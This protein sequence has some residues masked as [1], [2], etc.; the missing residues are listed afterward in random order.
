MAIPQKPL[1]EYYINSVNDL[2]ATLEDYAVY[3]LS[4]VIDLGNGSISLPL[5]SQLVGITANSGITSTLTNPISGTDWKLRVTNVLINGDM[6]GN[7]V[8][9]SLNS[10]ELVNL[11]TQQNGTTVWLEDLQILATYKNGKWF[12]LTTGNEV[13]VLVF[14]EDWESGNFTTNGWQVVNDTTNQWIVGQADPYTGLYSAYISN[15]GVNPTYT[16]NIPNVSHIYKDIYVAPMNNG[17]N[18]EFMFKGVLEVNYDYVRIY[19]APTTLTPIAGSLVNNTYRVGNNQYNNSTIYQK[20]TIK[21][22]TGY[23]GWYRLIISFRNDGNVG[24]DSPRIDDLLIT[25]KLP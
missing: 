13:E 4:T 7:G 11:T 20:K 23:G 17:L 22:L 5:H 19:L 14:K 24:G 9:P 12:D 16:N 25:Y 1:K 21:G 6:Q 3:K 2:P 18:I 8:F 15:N 10:V